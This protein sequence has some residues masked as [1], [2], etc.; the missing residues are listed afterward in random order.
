ML[1][2]NHVTPVASEA[3][4]ARN[5]TPP[6]PSSATPARP[7]TCPSDRPAAPAPGS[8]V[9]YHARRLQLVPRVAEELLILTPPDRGPG[10]RCG[11]E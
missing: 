8:A 2:R 3:R 5:S 4:Q 11:P 6:P 10:K 1:S 7:V 9:K